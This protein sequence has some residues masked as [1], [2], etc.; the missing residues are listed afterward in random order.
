MTRLPYE[1]IG[2][3]VSESATLDQLK[4]YMRLAEECCYTI[5]HLRKANDDND[6]GQAFLT[7]GEKLARIRDLLNT[8]ATSPGRMQ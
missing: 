7:I 2:G 1:T 6:T 8:V 4:E 3:Y 5:G